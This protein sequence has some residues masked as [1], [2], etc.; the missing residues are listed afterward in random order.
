MLQDLTIFWA[1]ATAPVTICTLASRRTPL[2]ITANYMYGSLHFIVTIWVAVW[3]FRSYSDDYPRY[4][5]TLAVTTALR[6]EQ[7]GLDVRAQ[8]RRSAKELAHVERVRGGREG[9]S[10]SQDCCELDSLCHVAPQ[11]ACEAASSAV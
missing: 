11:A 8:A 10:Q 9:H 6:T 2:I 4:R 3:L 1:L 5:N 7:P